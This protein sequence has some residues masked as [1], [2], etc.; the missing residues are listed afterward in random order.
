M[1]GHSKSS[2]IQPAALRILGIDPGSL[3]T[4]YGLIE[5]SGSAV[6][7]LDAGRLSCPGG[8]GVPQR[9][10]W[11]AQC[12]GERLA[13][14]QPELAVLET[15]FHGMNSR[16]LIVLAEARG[17]LLAVLAGRGIEIREYTPSEVKSAVTG[18]GRADKEQ[19]ARMVR[20]LVGATAAEGRRWAADATDAL[21]VALC[22][23]QR[24]RMDRLRDGAADPK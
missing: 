14:W 24:L 11:L 12:L 23:A 5:K 13:A 1:S 18:N 17:A 8:L 2:P 22:C 4:G 7:A 20:L 21:A 10:A 3:H 19:V 9:L 15:P 16:S 6:T